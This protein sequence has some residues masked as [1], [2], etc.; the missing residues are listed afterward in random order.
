MDIIILIL[1]HDVLGGSLHE[2]DHNI[3]KTW[4]M[5]KNMAS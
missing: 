5:D 2:N 3:I 1:Y 4:Q